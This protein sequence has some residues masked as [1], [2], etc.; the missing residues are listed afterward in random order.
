[1]RSFKLY[2]LSN[3]QIDNIVLLTTVFMLYVTSPGLI[4]GSLQVLLLS[5]ISPNLLLYPLDKF[6]L[7][8][9]VFSEIILF[10][11]FHI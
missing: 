3:F 1:M 4:T 7:Y 8:Q 2:Y 11:R 9:L 6:V 5:L 10:Y